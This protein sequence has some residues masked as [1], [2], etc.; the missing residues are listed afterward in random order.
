MRQPAG[1]IAATALLLMAEAASACAPVTRLGGG[2]LL[3]RPVGTFEALPFERLGPV[4]SILSP[5]TEIQQTGAEAEVES[6][7][8]E[9]ELPP[10]EAP[11]TIA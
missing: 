9:A 3:V 4:E 10:C 8:A 5:P 11:V 7:E 2:A 1:M 6:D